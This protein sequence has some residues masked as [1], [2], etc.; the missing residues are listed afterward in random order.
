M[1]THLDIS[2]FFTHCDFD[3]NIGLMNQDSKWLKAWDM[4]T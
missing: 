1:Q 2:D 3:L 4:A